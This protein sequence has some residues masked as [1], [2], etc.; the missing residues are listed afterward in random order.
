[1]TSRTSPKS[2]GSRVTPSK[3]SIGYSL[4]LLCLAPLALGQ[5]SDPIER[6]LGTWQLQMKESHPALPKSELLTFARTAAGIQITDLITVSSGAVFHYSG[7]MDPK[8]NFVHMREASGE[9]MNKEWRILS[10]DSD[11][12]IIETRPF[13]GRN[14]YKLGADGQTMT[15]S[16]LTAAIK[17]D[18]PLPDLTFQKTK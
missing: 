11:E 16:R 8:G 5:R 10:L 17:Y 4:V 7:V 3:L 18:P 14:K 12:L 6:F 2:I 9:L 13:G 15:M 1:M